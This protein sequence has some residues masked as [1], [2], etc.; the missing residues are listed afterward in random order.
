MEIGG[1][2][3]LEDLKAKPYYPDLYALNLARTAL[4]YLLET[5]KVKTIFVP[6]YLCDSVGAACE[7]KGFETL[8]YY[9]DDDLLPDFHDE[10][11]KDAYM[12]LVNHYG[13]LTNDKIATLQEKFER[14]IVDNTQ[15]FFQ[16]PVTSV[17]TFYSVRKFFGVSDGAYLYSPVELPKIQEQDES[18]D[19]MKHIL[20]RFEGSASDYYQ[21]MLDVAHA[22]YN[23]DVKQ[24]SNITANILGAID[25]E[26]VRQKRNDNYRTLDAYLGQ[27]NTLPFT[28]P[29][30]PL[31]YPFFHPEAPAI[32]KQLATEGIYSPT[33]WSNVIDTMD[34]ETIEYQYAAN[35]LALPIDQRY[36]EAEMKIVADAVLGLLN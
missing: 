19:R 31:S 5:L 22:Y 6:Y 11:P 9:L 12:L 18:H 3:G 32:R 34:E 29:D 33:Y 30:G 28:A 25:Y 24:M 21:D 27:Y 8:Y 14:V 1:Y 15:S 26:A 13:Q 16:R 23:E 20:G 2:L 17:P 10:L 7:R 35:I 4:V 36:G